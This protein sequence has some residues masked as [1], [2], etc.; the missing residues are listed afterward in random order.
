MLNHDLVDL[1]KFQVRFSLVDFK[2]INFY[3]ITYF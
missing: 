2:K 1:T 3:K